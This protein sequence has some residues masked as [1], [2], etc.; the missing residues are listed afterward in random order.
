MNYFDRKEPSFGSE[1]DQNVPDREPVPASKAA[2]PAP[3]KYK[4]RK[5]KKH[6][7]LYYWLNL[8]FFTVIGFSLL[9]IDFVLYA[10]SGSGNVFSAF[11]MMRPDVMSSLVIIG[12]VTAVIY[13]CLSGF[14]IMLCL[15]TGGIMYMFCTAMFSQFANFSSATLT[16]GH[17]SSYIALSLALVTFALLFF[18][19]KKIRFFFAC[20]AAFAFGAVLMHQNYDKPKFNIVENPEAATGSEKGR[21][22]INIMLPNAPAYGYVAGLEDSEAGKVYRDQLSSVMLGFYAKYGFKLFPNAYVGGRNPYINAADSLNFKVPENDLENLQTQVM[23]DSYWQFKNR[24]DFEAY[25]KNSLMLDQYKEQGYAVSAYQ[26][27][28]INLC[29]KNNQNNVY[30]CVTRI[31]NPVTLDTPLYSVFD[32]AGVLLAQWLESSGWFDYLGETLYNRL[33]SFVNPDAMPIAGMNYK[34]LYAVDAL[35]TLDVVSRHIA[36]DRGDNAY[37]VFLDMPSDVFVYDDMCK[38][39]SIGSWLPKNNQPWVGRNRVIEKRNA[40]FRQT[41]CLYGKL[42]QFMENLQ[43]SGE[44]ENTT[45]IIQG[46]SGMDDLLGD[47]DATLVKNFL[48]G[49]MAAAAIYNSENRRFTINKSVCS[50]PDILNQQFNGEKCEEF[51]GVSTSKTTKQAIRD[52]LNAVVY[53]NDSAQQAYQKYTDW[54]R[55]WNQNNFQSLANLPEKASGLPPE[56]IVIKAPQEA[57]EGGL[58]PLEERNLEAQPM[59]KGEVQVAPEAKVESLAEM[60]R[61]PVEQEVPGVNP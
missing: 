11:P 39:K 6:T 51:K 14:T 33:K 60:S 8:I 55:M 16:T 22:V 53:T 24:S 27:H 15:L 45:I 54:M 20:A 32:R 4:R 47:K 9:G 19:N 49:Q 2:Q 42:S 28:G 44:L 18:S 26:S 12:S 48:N 35:E 10:S 36:D 38:L 46:L 17:S 37:F 7:L 29:R 56:E 61:E 21:K 1:Q 41:M 25:L 3:K 50:I 58:P 59:M 57:H 13:F 23:K 40:Y 43:K 34:N 52:R 31:T 5:I 30:R